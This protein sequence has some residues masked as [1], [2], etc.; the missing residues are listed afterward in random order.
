[1]SSEGTT[2][3]NVKL[4]TI[5]RPKRNRIKPSFS[6][7][8][9]IG[10]ISKRSTL[11]N[12]ASSKLNLLFRRHYQENEK[13]NQLVTDTPGAEARRRVGAGGI[14]VH[15]DVYSRLCGLCQ[16]EGLEVMTPDG[17]KHTWPPGLSF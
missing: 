16:P 3:E 4:K 10:T 14:S 13:I 17:S 8:R 1:M 2:N 7:V 11:V 6:R 15:R 5:K 9:Q 12:W